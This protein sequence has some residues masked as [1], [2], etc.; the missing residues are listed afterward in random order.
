MTRFS[1]TLLL[2]GGLVACGRSDKA[3]HDSAA[4]GSA[5]AATARDT[6][7]AP[8]VVPYNPAAPGAMRS[9]DTPIKA[10]PARTAAPRAESPATPPAT[11][12]AGSSPAQPAP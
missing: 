2:L 3:A 4:A 5:R 12:A 10:A 8:R 6:A 11:R 9:G 1:L 7:P